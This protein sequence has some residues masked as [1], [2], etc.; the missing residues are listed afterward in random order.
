MQCSEYNA[1]LEQPGISKT[2]SD[3]YNLVES[4]KKAKKTNIVLSQHD[5]M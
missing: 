2:V 1:F 4:I 3:N 5:N